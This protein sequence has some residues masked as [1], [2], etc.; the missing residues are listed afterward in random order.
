MNQ[1]EKELI[2]MIRDHSDPER[3]LCV[4]IDVITSYLAQLEK[5]T[6]PTTAQDS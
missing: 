3:A 5:R 6:S 2:E 1:N 4:A